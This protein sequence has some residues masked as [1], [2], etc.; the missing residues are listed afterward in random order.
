MSVIFM[1][2]DTM[3]TLSNYEKRLKNSLDINLIHDKM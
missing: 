1:I 3:R 2:D